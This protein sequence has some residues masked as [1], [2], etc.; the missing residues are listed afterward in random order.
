MNE[1]MYI[2][3][4]KNINEIPLSEFQEV[5]DSID[6]YDLCNYII[7]LDTESWVP[8]SYW[9]RAKAKLYK[10]AEKQKEALKYP[11]YGEIFWAI[12]SYLVHNE[13]IMIEDEYWRYNSS[14]VD[15][16]RKR[17]GYYSPLENRLYQPILTRLLNEKFLSIS[18]VTYYGNDTYKMGSSYY[19]MSNLEKI[20]I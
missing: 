8:S 18:E 14:R 11:H 13:I 3:K 12:Y 20:N 10:D 9:S 5:I 1:L 6:L 17:D 15:K 2:E 4:N 7:S 16:Y 19:R